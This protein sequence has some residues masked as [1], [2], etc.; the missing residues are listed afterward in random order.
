MSGTVPGRASAIG[1][2]G[3]IRANACLVF[4]KIERVDDYLISLANPVR[5]V[6]AM[7]VRRGDG[8]TCAFHVEGI[9]LLE[10]RTKW[11]RCC[12]LLKTGLKYPRY[13]SRDVTYS[14]ISQLPLCS[15]EGHAVFRAKH[16]HRKILYSVRGRRYPVVN[17][18]CHGTGRQVL[19][20]YVRLVGG[21]CCVL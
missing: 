2:L 7:K 17:I 12:T 10:H 9:Y 20:G 3:L 19:E 13:G 6:A 14:K 1:A 16:D 21:A 11:M 18:E 5:E 4:P 15:L 8:S